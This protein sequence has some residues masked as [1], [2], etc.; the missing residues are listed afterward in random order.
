M[1]NTHQPQ[2]VSAQPGVPRPLQLQIMTHRVI[3]MLARN[4]VEY[5][6]KLGKDS[7]FSTGRKLCYSEILRWLI[8]FAMEVGFSGENVNSIIEFKE[9]LVEKVKDYSVKRRQVK[10]TLR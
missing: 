1:K 5:L 6:D 2:E 10:A 7:L 4:E 8:E 9:K 3:T